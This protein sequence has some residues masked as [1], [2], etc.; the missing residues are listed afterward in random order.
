MDKPN[1]NSGSSWLC[2]HCTKDFKKDMNPL[3]PA[4]MD[5]HIYDNV[6]FLLCY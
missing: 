2:S 5:E 4:V 3:V 6:K 1:S